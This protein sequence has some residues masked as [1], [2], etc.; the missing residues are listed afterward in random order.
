VALGKRWN[1]AAAFGVYLALSGISRFLV[2]FLRINQPVLL[3][4]THA[5]AL[6]AR[7][8]DRRPR[9]DRSYPVLNRPRRAA[10]HWPGAGKDE[11]ATARQDDVVTAR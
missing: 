9:P 1:P 2:E 8:P 7:Q 11:G 10:S 5:S 4:L 6:G 3:G